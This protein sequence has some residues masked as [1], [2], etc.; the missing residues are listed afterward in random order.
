MSEIEIDCV[1]VAGAV[2]L[3]SGVSSDWAKAEFGIRYSYYVNLRPQSIIDGAY[4]IDPSNIYPNGLEIFN[5]FT[6]I[7]REA[8]YTQP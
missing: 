1:H 3:I 5:G 8:F 4:D 6:A 2:P 7:C